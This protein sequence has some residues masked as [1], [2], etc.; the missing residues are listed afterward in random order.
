MFLQ[1]NRVVDQHHNHRSCPLDSQQVC[2]QRNLLDS[3][4]VFQARS[5]V[6]NLQLNRQQCLRR[7]QVV[8]RAHS[9]ATDLLANQQVSRQAGQLSCQ[10]PNR[11]VSLVTSLP[12]YPRNNLQ[13]SQVC[14][15]RHSRQRNRQA[16]HLTFHQHNPVGI[17]LHNQVHNRVH[18]QHSLRPPVLRR[19]LAVLRQFS[20]VRSPQCNLAQDPQVSQ[21]CNLVR[22][23]LLGRAHSPLRLH[24]CSHLANRAISQV[25]NQVHSLPPFQV[26]SRPFA[27]LCNQQVSQAGIPQDSLLEDHR[28]SQQDS[29]VVVHQLS[30]VLSRRVFRH[31]SLQVSPRRSHL[32]APLRSHHISLR[33]LRQLNLRVNPV[34]YQLLSHLFSLV[35]NHQVNQRDIRL[36]F[37]RLSRQVLRVVSLH[38]YLV[39][40]LPLSQVRVQVLNHL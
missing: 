32:A 30:Q 11:V 39:F 40:N 13:V 31:L 33:H 15:P 3:P 29:Q 9:Q 16:S 36:V 14:N 34:E 21:V 20:Q 37:R 1:D 26:L 24:R 17:L 4:L 12:Q 22:S 6:L 19:N 10:A 23:H 38:Q 2:L 18:N 5:Q 35:V 7:S 25:I 28:C 8:I 27:L